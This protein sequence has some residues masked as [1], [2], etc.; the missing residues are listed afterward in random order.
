MS[1]SR[2]S[3]LITGC[4][5][6]GIGA[7]LA[8]VFQEKGYHVFVTTRN[9]SKFPPNLSR[10]ENVTCLTLDVLSSESIAAA[11]ESVKKETGGTLDILI[12]NSGGII[13]LPALDTPIDD[14][15]RLF[16]LNFWAPFAMLQ[17]FAPLLI[18]AKGCIVNN[19][20]ASAYSP[21][22]L[23]SIYNSSKAALAMASETWR[24]ELQPLGVRT[25]TLITCAVKTEFFSRY[26]REELPVSSKYYD[27]RD[28]IYSIGDG[29][30]QSGAISSR[31]YATKVVREIEHG[32]AGVVW[33]GTHALLFRLLC[34]LLP[35]SL[36]DMV[37]ESVVPISSEMAKIKQKK[38]I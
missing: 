1:V 7:A 9:P 12:N 3:V 14:G 5:T 11:V 16:D 29:R 38:K 17:A 8:E 18:E 37:V 22:A 4:S 21:M 6:G 13:L 26:Q 19:S 28:F 25:I 33:A 23:T 20:S 36:F 27:I 32:S 30:L 35:N 24:H 10:A 2:K 15:K 34:W 31:Q